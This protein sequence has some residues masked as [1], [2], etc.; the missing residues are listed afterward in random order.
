[1][2]RYAGQANILDRMTKRPMSQIMKQ[3][4]DQK[5]FR[6]VSVDHSGKPPVMREPTQ[7]QKRQ[8]VNAQRMFKTGMIGCRINERTE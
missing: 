3:R 1:M 6:V 7:I 2:R 5:Q 8:T 4:R